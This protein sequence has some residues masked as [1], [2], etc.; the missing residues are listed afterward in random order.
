MPVTGESKVIDTILNRRSVRE[1]TDRPVSKDEIN[2]ILN[3]GRWAPSGLNNQPWRFIV[4]REKGTIMQ[5]SE[6]THYTKV[7]A[8][9]P[10]LIAVYLNTENSYSHTKDVQA[11]GAAIQNMLLAC[12]ELG[13]GAVWLGEILKQNEKVNSILECSSKLELMAVLAI[14]EPVPKERTSTRKALS[15]LVF[16]DR[17]G[18][19]WDK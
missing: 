5:L 2:T 17:Y 12:C 10:L 16:E 4:V 6:C 9:A 18:Q 13:L 7:V 19:K 15:E 8:G 11:I 1:F 14:G 3:A